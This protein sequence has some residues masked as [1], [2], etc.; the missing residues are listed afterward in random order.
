VEDARAVQLAE[1]GNLRQVVDDAGRDQQLARLELR[2]VGER[3]VNG[4]PPR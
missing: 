3:D 4:T 1:A 2:A